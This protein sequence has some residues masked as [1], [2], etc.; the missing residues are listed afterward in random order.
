MA[1]NNQIAEL[2]AAMAHQKAGRLSDA[3]KA[4]KRLLQ[5]M[6]GNFGCIYS[7]ATIYAQQGHFEAAADMFRRAAQ[8][9]PVDLEV[10]YNFA[11]ALSMSGQH[12]Q[13]A[14][15]YQK[16]LKTEPRHVGALNNYAATLLQQGRFA[17]ALQQYNRLIRLNPSFADAY[18]N[19]GMTL[20]NLTRFEE[21]LRDYDK[22]VELK[23]AFGQAYINRGNTLAALRRPDDALAS[24]NT[25]ISLQP[26]F[27]DAYRNVGNIY[28]ARGCYT[29]A[30][31]A[32]DR[33]L[34][35]QSDDWEAKSMRLNAKLHLCDWDSVD[36]D[37][38]ELIASAANG[39]PAYPFVA[40]A[41]SSSPE[42]Q[43]QC[44]RAFSRA[45]FPM[46]GKPHWRGKIYTHDRIRLA[47][48]SADLREHA[49]GY[50]LAGLFE[51]HD[52][53]HFEVVGVSFGGQASP[54]RRRIENALDRF[55]DVRDRSDQEIAELMRELEI[56]IA[57]DLMG[58]TRNA[59][60]GIF[61]R[62]PAPIQLSYL[63][64]LGTMG[65]D[66]MDYVIADSIALPFDQQRYY[67][68]K[69]V[70]LPD[71]F[72]VHDDR[73]A[74]GPHTPTRADAELP[75]DGFVF[76]S[77][78]S[79]YK[80]RRPMFE[81]WMRLLR[82]V[83][84]SVLWLAE[85]N[86]EMAVNLQR[87]AERCGVDPRRLVFA[88]RRPLAEH[89][90][91]QRLADLFLDTTPYN[92][93]ATAAGA[94]WA[95]IPVLTV[96]GKTFVG[97]MAASMLH[98]LGLPELVTGSLADYG[99]LALKIATEPALCATLK[100][101]LARNRENFPLFDTERSTRN[102]ESAYT[103]MWHIYQN[104]ERPRTLTVETTL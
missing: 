71:C 32:Y 11:V 58:Y 35:L 22:A 49:V 97:R 92:A 64:Y 91:R 88:P 67:S 81:L 90:A 102:L 1:S 43:F 14:T 4:Y 65:A 77:F 6:P 10:R 86:P 16:I 9:R 57:V 31:A 87:E 84:G 30:L 51:R 18:N 47:Y 44:A 28:S 17:D 59:R 63:G 7:L 37:W 50:L 13:A 66:F 46:S 27:A 41:A 5:Q 23:P 42:E 72:L 53:S 55:I 70:H 73:L 48:L 2:Q 3:A 101:K 45:C 15:N 8:I 68:E 39:T 96:L 85:A 20:Q 79:S 94:L 29:H 76:C 38:S 56:E 78:N 104:G 26:D 75:D 89:L 52:R 93:G 80:L 95:G 21:A 33:A 100:D 34:A 60:A 82:T 74:I 54:L 19:R 61:A 103:A 99:V 40:L 83:P 69:I 12:D 24:F 98:A 36:A 25:A 62:R